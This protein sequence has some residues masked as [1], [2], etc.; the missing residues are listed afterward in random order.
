MTG[1]NDVAIKRERE[2]L[3]TLRRAPNLGPMRILPSL[4]TCRRSV[5]D[6][7][8][9][10]RGIEQELEHSPGVMRALQY[11][12]GHLPLLEGELFGRNPDS[13]EF[14]DDAAK[15]QRVEQPLLECDMVDHGEQYP[16]IFQ[17]DTGDAKLP[18]QLL[19]LSGPE[20]EPLIPRLDH[21][22]REPVEQQQDLFELGAFDNSP[23]LEPSWMLVGGPNVNLSN[24]NLSARKMSDEEDGW[25]C[26]CR[27]SQG[28]EAGSGL[29]QWTISF[30]MAGGTRFGIVCLDQEKDF[31]FDGANSSHCVSIHTE[32]G[33][34]L[35]GGVRTRSGLNFG[36]GSRVHM[37]LNMNSG[38]LTLGQNGTWNPQPCQ[39]HL[40]AGKWYPFVEFYYRKREVTFSDLQ[41]FPD[42][43]SW[44][45]AHAPPENLVQSVD[46]QGMFSREESD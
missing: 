1:V 18:Q 13:Q 21:V 9:A 6:L 15:R 8:S 28:W 29:F 19:E 17:E 35:Y 31:N 39:S 7:A 24:S 26:A 37:L 14:Q 36:N 22:K 38:T 44:A 23:I 11:L 32:S 12:E 25:N 33:S 2:P 34:M 10:I 5:G 30:A 45:A 46:S 20:R 43:E 4:R 42:E 41:W 3:D 16:A 27:G 40:A